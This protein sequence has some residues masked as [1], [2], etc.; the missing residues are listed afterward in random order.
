[1]RFSLALYQSM[2]FLHLED[3]QQTK[4][5]YVCVHVCICVHKRVCMCTYMSTMASHDVFT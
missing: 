4:G 5:V 3:V 2:V 1:M